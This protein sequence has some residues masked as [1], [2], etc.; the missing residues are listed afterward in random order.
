[1]A[2]IIKYNK[3]KSELLEQQ[4]LYLQYTT[5]PTCSKLENIQI[6]NKAK[7]QCKII[8]GKISKLENDTRTI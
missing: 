8:K 7:Q 4:R 2:E 3:L 1:M 6:A 5:G